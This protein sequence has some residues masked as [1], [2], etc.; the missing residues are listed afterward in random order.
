[1]DD[2][3]Y[4]IVNIAKCNVKLRAQA[5]QLQTEGLSDAIN[6][7]PPMT[8]EPTNALLKEVLHLQQKLASL[9]TY[10]VSKITHYY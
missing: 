7:D 8:A 9:P 1:M 4:S 5:Q 10:Y 6:F 2:C 3:N